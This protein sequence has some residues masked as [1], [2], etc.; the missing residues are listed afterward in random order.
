MLFDGSRDAVTAC[1]FGL[2]PFCYFSVTFWGVGHASYL[3][4]KPID[5]WLKGFSDNA[6]STLVTFPVRE[7]VTLDILYI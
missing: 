3:T 1:Y 5:I 6:T 4:A 2:L 7:K